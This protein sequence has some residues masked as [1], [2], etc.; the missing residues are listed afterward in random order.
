[1]SKT[2]LTKLALKQTFHFLQTTTLTHYY[3]FIT[4]QSFFHLLNFLKA[5]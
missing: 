1:M 4:S 2:Q 3:S 5:H